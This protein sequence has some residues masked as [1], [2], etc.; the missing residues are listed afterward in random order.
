M[1]SCYMPRRKAIE[2]RIQLFTELGSETRIEIMQI[3]YAWTKLL[4]KYVSC[5]RT[6]TI[7]TNYKRINKILKLSTITLRFPEV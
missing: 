6:R 7:N 3:Q 2:V 1:Y 4:K 5:L